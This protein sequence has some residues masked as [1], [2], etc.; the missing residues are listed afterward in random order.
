[1][2]PSKK[3]QAPLRLSNLAPWGVFL[4]QTAYTY[5][6]CTTLVVREAGGCLTEKNS[7]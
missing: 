2:K 5:D 6:L 3:K 1:M 7:A 4:G